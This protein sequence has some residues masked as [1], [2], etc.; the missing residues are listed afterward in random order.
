MSIVSAT[1]QRAP[2]GRV[3]ERFTDHLGKGYKNVFFVPPSWSDAEVQAKV[4]A[5]AAELEVAIAEA[6]AR[7][8]IGSG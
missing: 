8:V 5:H 6:E 3:V 1:F 2:D 7:E 4:D